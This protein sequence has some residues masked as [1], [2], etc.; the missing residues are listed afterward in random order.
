MADVAAEVNEY[1]AKGNAAFQAGKNSEAI[2]WFTTAIGLDP[3]NH[4]LYS[5][6]SAAYCADKQYG[7]AL[8]DANKVVEIKPD[9]AKGWAR[10]GAAHHGKGEVK[11]AIAAYKKGLELEPG[12]ES[13]KTALAELEPI[14]PAGGDPFSKVFG[15]DVWNKIAAN[16]KLAGFLS[17]PDFCEIIRNIQKTPQLINSYL[18]DKRV[19][20]TF[21]TLCGINADVA[22]MET[23]PEERP[24]PPKPAH[25]PAP[26]PTKSLS[27]EE[28]ERAERE[29]NA[30]VEK[31]KGNE[32][33]KHKQ[34][35]EALACYDRAIEICPENSIYLINKSAVFFE[36]EKF[37]EC[38]AICDQAVEVGR[39]HR[40]DNKT[41]AKAFARK[42]AA[43]HKQNL[44]DQSI[45][46]YKASLLEHR[47]AETLAKLNKV[48]KEKK[49]AEVAAYVNP[50]LAAEA[51][52]RG[53]ALFAEQKFPAAI[54][55]YDE[56]I[57]RNPTEHT[58]YS[59][60]AAAYM[61]L[62]EYNAALKDCEKALELNPTYVKAMVRKAHIYFFRK[63]YHKAMQAYEE[64][65]KH[66]PKNEEL[67]SGL[68]R[69]LEKIQEGSSSG[70]VDEE[71][72]RKAM[73]DP[74]IQA[75][76]QDPVVQGVIRDFSENPQ[77]A[78]QH[79]RNPNIM[80]KLSKLIAAG[81]LKTGRA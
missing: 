38:I 14:G 48:E 68:Q 21:I 45:A 22:D 57:K 47:N 76:L 39:Q 27:P 50:A 10:K 52:E 56:A 72:V 51:K 19:M 77:A 65:L 17:Q 66:D 44:Y 71:R 16:P 11:E 78:Q 49:D 7:R 5:N 80:G 73:S 1:K 64:G 13:C 67:Q 69:T 8:T 33:Y 31:G 24:E 46:A 12:N 28:Q 62:G 26:A 9:W 81:I 74:E 6:R 42:A 29:K 18:Q 40:N 30:D 3:T 34:F 43:L 35:D 37:D 54:K 58:Y 60:R 15:P 75:I 41:I 63:E 20:T 25:K 55:E 53:N 70:E 61:K 36:Q 59:N 23:D 4:I 79:L 32:H 2:N